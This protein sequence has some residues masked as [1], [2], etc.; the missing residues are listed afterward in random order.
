MIIKKRVFD[1][2]KNLINKKS[3]LLTVIFILVGIFGL[4]KSGVIQYNP[5]KNKFKHMHG[6]FIKD[7]KA[8]YTLEQ[9]KKNAVELIPVIERVTGKQFKQIPEIKLIEG[10]KLGNILIREAG[11]KILNNSNKLIEKDDKSFPTNKPLYFGLYGSLDHVI[12][13]LPKRIDFICEILNL[14][15][16]HGMDIVKVIIAHELTHALQDQYLNMWHQRNSI[17][18]KEE[19]DAYSATVEGYAVFVSKKVAKQIGINKDIIDLFP[20]VKSIEKELNTKHQFTQTS[21]FQSPLNNIYTLGEQFINYHYEKGG[22]KAIWDI[23]A[24]LPVNIA[25][26]SNPELYTRQLY[27]Y[28]NYKQLLYNLYDY[29]SHYKNNQFIY[30]NN[31]ISQLDLDTF[32]RINNFPFNKELLSKIKHYQVYSVYSH[33]ILLVEIS[34]VILE[35]SLYASHLSVL[36]E[37][38]ISHLFNNIQD[39]IKKEPWENINIATDCVSSI[40]FLK[41]SSITLKVNDSNMKK[42]IRKNIQSIIQKNNMVIVHNDGTFNLT[43]CTV[44]KIADKI[45]SRYRNAKNKNY[46]PTKAN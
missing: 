5:E 44:G 7:G 20:L 39:Y 26:I 16:K 21:A 18:G 4:I 32:F 28:M 42:V 31:S 41:Q 23:L 38:F 40:D 10:K 2:M 19:L 46:Q 36:K 12:Y 35:N 30:K 33:D 11:I 8:F 37:K 34:F 15:K 45:F 27:D 22:N 6:W 43:P 14:D 3:K 1:K 24:H 9:A 13:L 29:Q 17:P 25:M